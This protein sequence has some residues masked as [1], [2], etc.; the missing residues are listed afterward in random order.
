M[1]RIA[2]PIILSPEERCTLDT[3]VRGRRLPVRLVQRAQIIQMAADGMHS[4]NIA[5]ELMQCVRIPFTWDFIPY[6]SLNSSDASWKAVPAWILYK[7]YVK[8]C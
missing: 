2:A 3:W 8:K 5:Q 4:Q 6:C 7:T 1:S